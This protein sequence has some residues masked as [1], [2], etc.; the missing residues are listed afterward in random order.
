MEKKII[1]DTAASLK[2]TTEE[3]VKREVSKVDNAT[4]KGTAIRVALED[5]ET[6]RQD[7]GALENKIEGRIESKSKRVG[8][9]L[10]NVKMDLKSMK[11]RSGG[12]GSGAFVQ[13]PP[14]AARQGGKVIGHL[15][16]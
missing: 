9:E 8:D 11:T 7:N 1:E 4:G 13:P 14:L 6:R 15:E 16:R 2:S 5:D 10:N 12:L 3:V